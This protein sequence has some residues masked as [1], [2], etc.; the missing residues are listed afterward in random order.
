M[1]FKTVAGTINKCHL[2]NKDHAAESP[3]V[4][5]ISVRMSCYKDDYC[6]K[7]GLD[8]SGGDLKSVAFTTLEECKEECAKTEGCVAFTTVAGTT[9]LCFLKNKDHAAE[10]ANATAISARMS[11][12]EG[13]IE[14]QSTAN[15]G[16]HFLCL[17]KIE[18]KQFKIY[19]PISQIGFVR[20]KGLICTAWTSRLWPSQQ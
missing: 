15:C 20:K 10:S 8:L 7:R 13:N 4:K 6:L 1:A 2:K 11:C 19:K 16:S 18:C 9:N 12:Y 14:K 3:N 17:L 5:A